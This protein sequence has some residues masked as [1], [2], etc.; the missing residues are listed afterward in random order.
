MPSPGVVGGPLFNHH[1]SP[2]FP[3]V[4]LRPVCRTA[5]DVSWFARLARS[6]LPALEYCSADAPS[7]PNIHE[8]IREADVTSRCTGI[9]RDLCRKLRCIAVQF[10]RIQFRQINP[11]P[12]DDVF[13]PQPLNCWCNLS[14]KSLIH[15]NIS[16]YNLQLLCSENVIIR[17]L[18]YLHR[19]YVL[20]Y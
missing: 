4:R 20:K 8:N 11:L 3:P 13:W 7:K 5:S 19:V 10:H 16:N 9:Y 18:A 15:W 1:P 12:S 14:R 2:L 6:H 17:T